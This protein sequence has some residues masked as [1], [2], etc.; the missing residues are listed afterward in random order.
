MSEATCLK[1]AMISR[2][3]TSRSGPPAVVSSWR[4]T[5]S[6]PALPLQ[7]D[8]A[9]LFTVRRRG[10]EPLAQ[11]DQRDGAPM[12]SQ[13][14]FEKIRRLGERRGR[15]VTQDALDLKDVEGEVLAR[16]LER[17]ELDVVVGTHVMRSPNASRSRI[18]TSV[19]LRR[20][21]PAAHGSDS[22]R[23]TGSAVSRPTSSASSPSNA[24]R[25]T[26]SPAPSSTSTAVR[27]RS[28]GG[29]RSPSSAPR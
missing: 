8:G 27:P 4:A 2:F 11:V 29:D 7:D 19:P 24:T 10:A 5:V 17:D 16:H 20:A 22:P 21:T 9:G 12:I 25:R 14:A 6:S 23:G 18:G 3:T 13:H 1:K 15:L 28:G 26:P